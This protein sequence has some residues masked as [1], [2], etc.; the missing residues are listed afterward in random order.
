MQKNKFRFQKGITYGLVFTTLYVSVNMLFKTDNLT[1]EK[2]VIA[3]LI[4][5]FIS[6]FYS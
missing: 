4:G 6:V 3:L 5:I 2:I 1:F